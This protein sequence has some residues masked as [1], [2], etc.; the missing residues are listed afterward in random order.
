MSAAVANNRLSDGRPMRAMEE[1]VTQRQ[2]F[3]LSGKFDPK[4]EGVAK[5]KDVDDALNT[6]KIYTAI[7]GRVWVRTDDYGFFHRNPEAPLGKELL[8]IEDGTVYK[9]IIPDVP[10]QFKGNEISL[11]KVVG[12]GVYPSIGLLQIK[13]TDETEFT[14]SP[15]SLD[16]IAGKV[17]AMKFARGRWAEPDEHGFPDGD[18]PSLPDLFDTA[19]YGWIRNDFDNLDKKATGYHGS[20]SRGLNGAILGFDFGDWRRYVDAYGDWSLGSGVALV[21]HEAAST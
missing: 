21:D 11:Q 3:A 9:K 7:M 4:V 20:F 6:S 12:M 13:Q 16:A 15:V 10:V 1:S 17:R 14:V 2:M 5:V 19:R 18:R 8:W